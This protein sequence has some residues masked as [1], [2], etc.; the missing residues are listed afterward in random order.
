MNN[1]LY[2]GLSRQETLQR[3]LELTA[4]NIANADTAG[5][6]LES[7]LVQ[8]EPAT[9]PSVPDAA[10]IAYVLDHGVQRDFTQGEI[11]HTGNDYDVAID[12]QGFLQAQTA[13]GLRYTRD[14]RLGVDTQNQLV[15][16]NGDPILDTG[17]RPIVLNPTGGPPAIGKDGTVTQGQVT[18]GRIAIY[19]FAD[20]G[21]LQKTGNNYLEAPPAAPPVLAT[22][23]VLRQGAIEHANVQP[24][25]EITNL[26]EITR[27]YE[28]VAQMMSQTGDLSEQAISRLGKAA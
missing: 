13:A 10:P 14:G 1:A 18:V 22:D 15:T 16:R 23:G 7:L 27:A 4:N 26:I 20:L 28:R 21:Q 3:A 17:G 25:L 9:P 11:E 19:R 2:V 24:I 6:K 5:F 8:T 12:G